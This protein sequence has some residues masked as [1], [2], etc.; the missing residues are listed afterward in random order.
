MRGETGSVNKRLTLLVSAILV[1]GFFIG[2]TYGCFFK[3]TFD[4][5][6]PSCGITHAWQAVFCGNLKS[7][8]R[9]H[10]M[11]WFPPLALFYCCLKKPI[12]SKQVDLW[13]LGSLLGIYFIVYI[14]RLL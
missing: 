1:T 8:I 9:L 13:I 10:P 5:I 2:V 3:N 11:F 6:C 14:S 4:I 12:I 7:A